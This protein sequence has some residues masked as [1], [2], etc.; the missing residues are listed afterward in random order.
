MW[1]LLIFELV[2]L[3]ITVGIWFGAPLVGITSVLPRVVIILA[4]L[5]PPVILIVAMRLRDRKA[6]RG[7]EGAI[8][9]Q[10]RAHEE[11]ARPDRREEIEALREAFNQAV[12]A[13]K[14]SKVGRGGIYAMPWYMIIGP[15]AVGKS[16]ALL[17]SGLKFPFTT[18]DRKA[19]KGLGGTRNC[20][21]TT[22]P[23]CRTPPPSSPAR[24]GSGLTS[25]G[26]CAAS[27]SAGA[28]SSRWCQA[29]SSP[30]AWSGS[31]TRPG[32]SRG[33]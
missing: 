5:L 21:A 9:E 6:A 19:I 32:A 25:R 23:R 22:T 20:A 15:P 8:K 11:A 31:T 29:S 14:K 4:L 7:L 33:R 30:A 17:H 13:V 3:A 27:S 12:A 18:G 24:A 1:R 10:G 28:T 2:A 16:T 26:A